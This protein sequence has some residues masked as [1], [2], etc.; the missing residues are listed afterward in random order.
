MKANIVGVDEADVA[1]LMRKSFNVGKPLDATAAQKADV[2]MLLS[3]IN[4]EEFKS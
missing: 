1:A 4:N 2:Q 3:A